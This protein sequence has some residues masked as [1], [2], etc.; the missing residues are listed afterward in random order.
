MIKQED[1]NQ[2]SNLDSIERIYEELMLNGIDAVPAQTKD[3]RSK[4]FSKL[5][6]D[7]IQQYI[8]WNDYIHSNNVM[9]LF[10]SV[11]FNGNTNQKP[12]WF[13][14]YEIIIYGRRTPLYFIENPAVLFGKIIAACGQSKAEQHERLVAAVES[15]FN[16]YKHNFLSPTVST[17]DK[18][19]FSLQFKSIFVKEYQKSD[20]NRF[21]H[22]IKSVFDAFVE[23]V[24][25]PEKFVEPGLTQEEFIL[26]DEDEDS[27]IV[28][29]TACNEPTRTSI[30]GTVISRES[31][32]I[33][34]KVEIQNLPNSEL[35]Y[36][37]GK[38]IR[39]IGALNKSSIKNKL[40]G[41]SKQYGFVVEM[42]DDYDKIANM[43]FSKM[44]YSNRISGIIAGPMPHK[45]KGMGSYSSGLEMLRSE[46]GYPPVFE[47]VAGEKLKITSTSLW[48][49]LRELNKELSS[50]GF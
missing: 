24:E 32:Q 17:E 46:P 28:K 18:E 8:S 14:R 44:R 45:I 29:E 49:A 1:I 47:C 15:L 42:Y 40:H 19:L 27:I 26:W 16:Y 13:I 50:V 12:G 39:F 37:R 6:H 21:P 43:D 7:L 23:Y 36:L 2:I 20:R 38:T 11:A 10:K 30:T 25:N 48:P 41:I 34:K 9:Q 33:L 31:E 5:C 3:I 22:S 35:K 4:V